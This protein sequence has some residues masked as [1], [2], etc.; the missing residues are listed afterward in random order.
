MPVYK[1]EDIVVNIICWY[2]NSMRYIAMY[3]I[4]RWK[5]FKIIV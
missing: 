1:I 5:W 3:L 4:D 2:Y